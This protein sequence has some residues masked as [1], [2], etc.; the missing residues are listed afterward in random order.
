METETETETETEK[1]ESACA[2]HALPHNGRA[3][4]GEECRALPTERQLEAERQG[5]EVDSGGPTD[6]GGPSVRYVAPNLGSFSSYVSVTSRASHPHPVS[7]RVSPRACRLPT[8]FPRLLCTPDKQH[9]R[10]RGNKQ[11][12][13]LECTTERICCGAGQ[14]CTAVDTPPGCTVPACTTDADTPYTGCDTTCTA[15]DTPYAGCTQAACTTDAD[16]PYTGC[17]TTCTAVDTPYA[18]CIRPQYH[19]HLGLQWENGT[20]LLPADFVAQYMDDSESRQQF[21]ANCRLLSHEDQNRSSSC[22]SYCGLICELITECVA[23]EVRSGGDQC[24]MFSALQGCTQDSQCGT[25]GNVVCWAGFCARGAPDNNTKLIGLVKRPESECNQLGYEPHPDG[26][27]EAEPQSPVTCQSCRRRTSEDDTEVPTCSPCRPC[28]PGRYRDNSW[29]AAR[30]ACVECAAGRYA[31][32][33]ASSSCTD[34]EAGRY[35]SDG[36]A[37]SCVGC[38]GQDGIG[39]ESSSGATSCAPCGAGRRAVGNVCEDCIAGRWGNGIGRMTECIECAAGRYV[40]SPGSDEADDCIECE[41]QAGHGTESSSGATS[42]GACVAGRRAVGW[43]CENCTAG[44]WANDTGRTA[45]CIGCAA[46]RFVSSSGNTDPSA[47]AACEAGRYAGASG[48]A[49]CIAC[50]RGKYV[51]SPGS[52][53]AGDCIECQGPDGHGTESSS[54]AT[55]CET[56]VAGRRAVGGD[57]ENCTAVLLWVC[58]NCTAGRWADDTGRTAECIGCAAGRY[59]SSSGNTNASACAACEPGRYGTPTRQDCSDCSAG[60]YVDVPGSHSA[61]QCIA[62]AAGKYVNATGS[63]QQSDC[64]ECLAGKYSSTSGANNSNWCIQ[65]PDN[66]STT[67]G[68]SEAVSDCL[69]EPGLS[70]SDHDTTNSNI[71]CASCPR[72]KSGLTDPGVV[73]WPGSNGHDAC[74]PCAAGRYKPNTGKPG[75]RSCPPHMTSGPEAQDL[76]DCVCD[77]VFFASPS[78]GRRPDSEATRCFKLPAVVPPILPTAGGVYRLWRD[79]PSQTC[80][81]IG[82]KTKSA[83]IP[84]GAVALGQN[85]WGQLVR[86]TQ[87]EDVSIPLDYEVGIDITPGQRIIRSWASIVHFTAT[88]SNCCAYGD[89]IPGVWFWPNTRKLLVVDGHGA[90]GQSHTG[91]WGCSD[92][93]LTLAEGVTSTLKMVMRS[94]SVSI[95]VDGVLACDEPRANRRVFPTVSVYMANPW[96]AAADANVANLYINAGLYSG[97]VDRLDIAA[98]PTNLAQLDGVSATGSPDMDTRGN[99]N[100]VINMDHTPS[101]WRSSPTVAS[102]A[103][104]ADQAYMTIDL[105]TAHATTGAT[106]WHY[107]GN[108]RAYCSQKIAMSL[109]GMFTGEE[110][111]VFDTG[112]CSGWCTFPITCENAEAGDCTPDNYGPTEAADGNIFSWAPT[113]GRYLRHWSGRGQNSGVHFMEID[114]YGCA[115]E[116]CASDVGNG[117]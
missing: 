112:T 52:D 93:V 25:A 91:E 18:G 27:P 34:C 26:C 95:Y 7:L 5:D 41:G 71:T 83:G 54:G 68:G 40:S 31:S 79:V 35:A 113:H 44:R 63:D 19:S 53:E 89:R 117:R 10:A 90:N 43:V 82:S 87:I 109:T 85:N 13:H 106:I 62:C 103:T 21:L 28:A 64:S 100:A 98:G 86:N 108:D 81:I 58:E 42:C 45:E 115:G 61:S 110:T 59:V 74:H 65:C 84:D 107:Y 32:N 75:C 37:N 24:Y 96:Y 57:C 38:Q 60:K 67:G 104:C 8:T 1:G 6:V 2:A 36:G 94:D 47:C 88:D 12:K 33:N 80:S 15:V 3:K 114:V 9:H 97:L 105:G 76:L 50:D 11:D 14:V 51:S 69:C 55:S 73:P 23:F 29:R 99:P 70:D 30:D 77:A 4:A 111:V 102:F 48:A 46:G 39:T 49:A 101:A 17:D 116:S 78:V 66:S 22:S 16:T 56:C 72:G 92:A 20:R